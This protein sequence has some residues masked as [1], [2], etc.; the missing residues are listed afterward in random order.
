MIAGGTEAVITP[1]AVAGFCAMRALST[2]NDE[3]EKAS[4]P[5]DAD[6]DGFVMGEGCG[7]VVL[8]EMETAKR[9]GAPHLRRGR[10][11]RHERRRLPHLGAASGGRR[12]GAR[13]AGRPARR[14]AR[15]GADRLHQ[16][17][18]HL[19]AARRP[20]RGAGDQERLRRPRLQA[21]GL[22]H[23]IAAPAT[24]WAPPAGSR[25]AS[26]RS[27]SATRSCRRRSTSTSRARAA[28]STSSPT[29]ARKVDLEYAAQQ[30]LRLRRHQRVDHLEALRGGVG[31]APSS[32]RSKNSVARCVE[33]AHRGGAEAVLLAGVEGLLEG[34]AGLDQRA[35]HLRP[36]SAGGRC[37]PPGRGRSAD[38][39]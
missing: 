33:V 8:E 20:L 18:R 28:T 7:I 10:G 3:P 12:R 24:C 26:W 22:L 23:Q 5:W 16:R 37:R 11:L 4:R 17:P 13:D 27:P 19:D 35:A 15:A 9:R 2:R 1:L 36:C 29:R 25:P 30:L 32:S 34:E 39:P 21:G 6:R 31:S 38:G 14:R